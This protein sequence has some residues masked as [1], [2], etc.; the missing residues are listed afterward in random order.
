M[1]FYH[2]KYVNEYLQETT[3]NLHI[4]GDIW[5]GTGEV[6]FPQGRFPI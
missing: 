6:R 5:I 4:L 2:G 1:A 3:P